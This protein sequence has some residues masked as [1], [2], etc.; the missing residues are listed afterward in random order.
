MYAWTKAN[1]LL[2]V[3][4]VLGTHKWV[5]LFLV[6]LLSSDFWPPKMSDS[7]ATRSSTL[8]S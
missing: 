6:Y 8:W 2:V 3:D 7:A 5:L 4:L 1:E